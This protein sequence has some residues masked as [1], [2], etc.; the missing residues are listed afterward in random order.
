M[1]PSR[2]VES[3]LR[4]P[5]DTTYLG[6]LDEP[7][8]FHRALPGYAPTPLKA[9][10]G[11]AREL[12]LGAVWVKDEGRRFGLNAFK[13][14][15]ASYALHKIA[16]TLPA[17]QRITVTT[18]TA[19]NHGRAV[20][21]AARR[22][23]HDAVVFVPR[24]TA[25]ARIDA[26]HA[27]GARCEIVDGTYDEAVRLAAVEAKVHGWHVVSDTS[28]AGYDAVPAWIM[29]GY[30]TLFREA[31]AQ[32]GDAFPTVA[33][34][35]A[36]VGGLALA[37]VATLA[38]LAPRPKLVAVEPIEADCLATSAA[39]ADGAIVQGRGGQRSMM[40]GLNAGLVS[41]LAWP[42]LRGALDGYLAIDDAWAATAMRRYAHPVGD[43]PAVRAGE[44][45]AAGLGGLLALCGEPA[46]AGVRRALGLDASARV[47][48]VCTEADTDP[49]N[50][51]HV[52]E[53]A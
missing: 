14:L 13:C 6:A 45:G 52:V 47:L 9:L 50:Y 44:S 7:E 2:W 49:V 36:G 18:A 1:L 42:A 17:G 32:L 10:P 12:G 19:G 38:P 39:S 29:A 25:T 30:T 20:A 8:A 3:H 15:G 34:L 28:W 5:I 4:G 41:K 31:L 27:E 16:A 35:Q 51:R 26:I 37:G 22:L 46:L 24:G 11:L 53:G 48:V 33:M 23:G 43:D 40:A 21:W